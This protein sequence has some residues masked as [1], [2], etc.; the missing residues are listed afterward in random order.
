[1][2]LS[3]ENLASIKKEDVPEF[4]RITQMDFHA[5]KKYVSGQ[6]NEFHLATTKLTN[7]LVSGR[8][9]KT[10]ENIE[11]LD[12]LNKNVSYLGEIRHNFGLFANPAIRP[13]P[14]TLASAKRL[15]AEYAGA[16]DDE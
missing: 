16:E 11:I 15:L 8:I 12:F 14:I 5:L 7:G 13:I 2:R 1:M 4:F 9:P 6:I 3:L 10:A